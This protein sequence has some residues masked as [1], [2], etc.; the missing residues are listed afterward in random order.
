MPVEIREV[1]IKVT[2]PPPDA[3]AAFRFAA[4]DAAGKGGHAGGV[5]IAWGDGSVRGPDDGRHDSFAADDTGPVP[6]E[7]LA[8]NF[9]KIEFAD[10]GGQDVF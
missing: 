1:Q 7:I 4:S 5:N 6:A 9:A 10:T 8:L 3:D 2:V